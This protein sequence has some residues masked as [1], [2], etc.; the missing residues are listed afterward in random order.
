MKKRILLFSA[1]FASVGAAKA[2]NTNTFPST[3]NVGIGT[4]APGTLLDVKGSQSS[5]WLTT[6][7]NINAIGHQMYFGYTNPSG[8]AYGL[9][10]E[11]AA[12][13]N[14]SRY[15]Q[16]GADKFVVRGDGY[17]GIGTIDPT[18]KFHV[19]GGS[20]YIQST[21][22][23]GGNVLTLRSEADNQGEYTGIGL[24]VN[25][26]MQFGAIRSILGPTGFSRLGLFTGDNAGN[27]LSEKFSIL[28]NNGNVGIGTTNPLQKFVVSNQGADGFEVY[29]STPGLIGLQAYN[30]ASSVYSKMQFDASQFG[31]M[32]GKVGIGTTSPDKD[33][34]IK[35]NGI[36]G[37][38]YTANGSGSYHTI[39]GGGIDPMSFTVAPFSDPAGAIFKFNGNTGTKVTILNGGNVGIGTATPTAGLEIMNPTGNA[40]NQLLRLNS[41]GDGSQAH[42]VRN[43]AGYFWDSWTHN[44]VEDFSLHYNPL[45]PNP[46]LAFNST[47]LVIRKSGNIG[48]GTHE[49]AANLQIGNS[50]QN[51]L[52]NLGGYSNIGCL[53]SSGDFFAGRNVY[54]E[55]GSAAENDKIKVYQNSGYGFSAMQMTYQGDINFYAKS[56]A[57]SV[58]EQANLD[59]YNVFKIAGDGTTYARAIEITMDAFPDYVFEK[60]YALMTLSEVEAYI[61]ANKHLP[62]VPSASELEKNGANVADLM[63]IQMEKIEELTLYLIEMKKADA[64]LKKENEEI[65]KQLL[66]LQNK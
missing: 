40:H 34:T 5:N 52:I 30:R 45:D 20:A 36:I 31:F 48:I 66:I 46:M 47:A 9:Y 11:G 24:H 29:L 4:T 38:E 19:Y 15:L 51:G 59:A 23:S 56:G 6:F 41:P 53:R 37:F 44:D 61:K 33:L 65:K 62:N 32:Y 54:A 14:Y 25:G 18:E 21:S 60:E 27:T 1:I 39:T 22:L 7:N 13:A 57:V 58:N 43:A 64:E 55:Y 12:N 28:S 3:G 8:T 35:S 10:I 17:V 42:F 49:P 63:K 16:L 2:Q 50:T 26:G